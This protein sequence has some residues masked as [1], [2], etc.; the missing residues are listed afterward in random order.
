MLR[1]I[2][3]DCATVA[4]RP[5]H[6]ERCD[7]QRASEM[8]REALALY[9]RLLDI[10]ARLQFPFELPFFAEPAWGCAFTVLDFGC[11]DGSYL[12]RLAREFPDKRY[13]GVDANPGMLEIA[14]S[15]RLP[16]NITF[17][18]SLDNVPAA[19]DFALMRYVAMH[20]PHRRQT[21]GGIAAKLSSGSAIL[22][23]EP[24]DSELRVQPVCPVLDDA[25]EGIRQA[26]FNRELAEVLVGDMSSAGFYQTYESSVVLSDRMPEIRHVVPDYVRAVIEI[27]LQRKMTKSEKAS[28]FDWCTADDRYAQFGFYGRLYE[29]RAYG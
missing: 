14:R 1:D 2:D 26:S 12:E 6:A 9:A 17:H 7:D 10:Q 15:R 13:F 25:L 8:S 5:P 21:I 20:L 22:V 29:R 28:V 18:A 24:N 16:S 11:G 23:I 27:G 19:P 3:H 4:L